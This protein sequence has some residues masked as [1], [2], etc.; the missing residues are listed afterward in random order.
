M[1]P[2]NREEAYILLLKPTE[3]ELL[4]TSKKKMCKELERATGIKANTWSNQNGLLSSTIM[5]HVESA[6]A[7]QIFKKVLNSEP[8][9][10]MDIA[11]EIKEFLNESEV[12]NDVK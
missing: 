10:N 4:A 12:N 8:Q 11:D 2:I 1:K 9:V 3:K 7:K 5:A 6:Y